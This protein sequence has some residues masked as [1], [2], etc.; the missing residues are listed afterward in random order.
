MATLQGIAQADA[1]GNRVPIHVR[2]QLD[3]LLGLGGGGEPAFGDRI[4]SIVQSGM[5]QQEQQQ[6]Q[7]R[8]KAPQLAKSMVSPTETMLGETT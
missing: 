5:A 4:A 3:L 6:K 1:S 2:Q 7:Q 8:S